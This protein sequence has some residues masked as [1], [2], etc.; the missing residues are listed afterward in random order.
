MDLV[1]AEAAVVLRHANA[2]GIEPDRAFSDLGYD[3]LTSVELRNRLT[4]ASGVRLPATLLFDHPTPLA[5]A[6]YLKDELAGRR[7]ATTAVAAVA[8]DEPIAIVG[9]ACRFPGGVASPEQLWDLVSGE[10]DAIGAFPEDRG[11]DLDRL[12]DP[13]VEHRGTSYV[14]EGGFLEDAAGFDAGFF[15]ISPREALAMDPQQRVLLETSWEA[16]ERAGID[17]V[18]LRGSDVGVFAGVM[19]QGYL[20]EAGLVPEEIEGYLGTG[21][22]GSVVSGR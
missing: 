9:M 20:P 10:T 21:N 3:S 15:G 8:A 19:Y 4:A 16:F 18:S 7:P 1:R 11:W 22:S 2:D 5:V 14:R 6:A 17:P 12:F 13:D